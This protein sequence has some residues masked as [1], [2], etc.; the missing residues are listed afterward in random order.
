[1]LN[2]IFLH[3]DLNYANNLLSHA[4]QLFNAAWNKQTKYTVSN[5]YY[6]YVTG[7]FPSMVDLFL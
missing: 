6:E 2:A 1:M 5:N 4:R 7:L 3:T